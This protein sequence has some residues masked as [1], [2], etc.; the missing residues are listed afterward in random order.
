MKRVEA[1]F[2]PYEENKRKNTATGEH[3]TAVCPF[4][5]HVNWAWASEMDSGKGT[6][7]AKCE[8]FAAHFKKKKA[9]FAFQ[10]NISI[11]RLPDEKIT[12]AYRKVSV[13]NHEFFLDHL[14]RIL[15]EEIDPTREEEIILIVMGC[16]CQKSNHGIYVSDKG[17]ALLERL[18]TLYD[19]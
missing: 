5:Q 14:L 16:L 13:E 10:K 12:T 4:C 2:T 17:K 11:L 7:N 15:A 8:H 6:G 9:W 19:Y 1:V 18:E 3:W